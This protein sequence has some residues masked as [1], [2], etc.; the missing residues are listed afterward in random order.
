MP[1]MSLFTGAWGLGGW[2]VGGGGVGEG[3]SMTYHFIYIFTF[4]PL[5]TTIDLCTLGECFQTS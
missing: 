3:H 4:F 1:K 2:G 5:Q